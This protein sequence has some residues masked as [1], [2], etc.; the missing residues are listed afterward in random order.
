MEKENK[1][2]EISFADGVISYRIDGGGWTVNLQDVRLIGEY[3]TA[4]GPLIDD[5]FFVFLTAKENGWHEAS[6]YAS[7]LVMIV[8]N[9]QGVALGLGISGFQPCN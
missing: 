5:Y 3:T 2:G 8:R 6:F 9:S 1:S 4:N 7:G